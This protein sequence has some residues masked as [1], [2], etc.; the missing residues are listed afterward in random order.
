MEE[1]HGPNGDVI[2]RLNG[3]L[4]LP[5]TGEEQD[6]EIEMADEA[7]A[8][9][10]LELFRERRFEIEERAALALLI[11]HSI[12]SPN[13]PEDT[14]LD[15]VEQMRSSLQADPEVRAR[16]VSYWSRFGYIEESPEIRRMLV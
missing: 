5:A 14:S 4:D 7:R 3:V 15:L 11:T 10:W 6:W 8:S 2:T 13:C 1:Y 16:L 9:E 12:Y